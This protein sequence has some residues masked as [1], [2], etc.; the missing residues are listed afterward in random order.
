LQKPLQSLTNHRPSTHL[1][2]YTRPQ[3]EEQ[4][5]LTPKK[6]PTPKIGDIVRYYDIDGGDLKGQILVGKISLIQPIA[7]STPNGQESASPNDGTNRWLVEITQMEDV[8]EGYYAE[9]PSRKRRKTDLR[10]L[11]DISPLAAS[12]VRTEDAYKIPMERGTNI[13]MAY[14]QYDLINYE[15]PKSVPIDN[16]V[17]AADGEVYNN[18][19]FSLLKNTALAGLAG[20]LVADLVRGRED[21]VIYFAGATAGVLYLYFL[22]IKTDTLGS[23]DAKLG[24]NV[25]NLR[26]VFPALVLIGV[27]LNNVM[28]GNPELAGGLFSTVTPEQFGAAMIGFLTYRVP[29]FVSQLFPVLFDSATDMLPGSAGMVVRMAAEAKKR[30]VDVSALDE[31]PDDG[32]VTV[33]LVSGPESTGKTTLVNKLIESDDRFVRP[34]MQDRILDPIR[35][36]RMEERDEFLLVDESGRY[37]LSKDGVLQTATKA[38][39]SSDSQKVVVLDANVSLAQKLSAV[40]EARLVGV[41]VGLDSLEKYESRFKSKIQSGA[42][43]IPDGQTE[44]SMLRAKV[45]QAMKDIEYG[46]TSGVFEFTILN[47]DI[48]ESVKELKDAAEYCFK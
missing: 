35:F 29:L 7:A 37:G 34:I 20:T 17:F 22:G 14:A 19:K 16:D 41:W 3:D 1:T 9:Y 15:G 5:K 40:S 42:I 38:N 23:A 2:G 24:A 25:S 12:F 45:N 39:E 4:I 47:D 10:K 48:E 18:V 32:L 33:L 31:K 46:I 36:E 27:A 11:E 8:G 43:E 21:A 13:P 26:F 30:G 6:L 28:S 44:E